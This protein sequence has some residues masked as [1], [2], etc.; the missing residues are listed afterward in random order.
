M[1]NVIENCRRQQQMS[2]TI[3]TFPPL[4]ELTFRHWTL[5]I[6]VGLHA[7][8]FWALNSE[9][10]QDFVKRVLPR[11]VLLPF[12]EP[13]PKPKVDQKAVIEHIDVQRQVFVPKP[14]LPDLTILIDEGTLLVPESQP[15]QPAPLQRE[16]PRDPVVTAPQIDARGGLSEPTYPASEIRMGHEG[17]VLLSVF[18]LENGR[19][20]DV[21]VDQ[22]SGYAK[23]DAAA[24]REARSWRL[25][26]GL[27]DGVPV[28]MWKQIPIT[29]QLRDAEKSPILRY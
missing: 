1:E 14:D 24:M 4:N 13:E 29:F 27:R 20:G 22:S 18:V 8:A 5:L 19:V 16:F 11:S 10:S 26:P 3:H 23:L 2:A 15:A 9:L 12:Q 25:K 6:I 21:R 7:A 17:T 28:A